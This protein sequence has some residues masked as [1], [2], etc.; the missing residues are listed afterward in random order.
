L[1]NNMLCRQK[2]REFN[3]RQ[4]EPFVTHIL[5]TAYCALLFCAFATL[6]SGAKTAHAAGKPSPIII[7][8]YGSMSG[9]QST[10]GWSTDAGVQLAVEQINAAGGI[11]G[12]P[13]K[14]ILVDDEGTPEGSLNAVEQIIAK[15]KPTAIIGEVASKLSISAAPA[16]QDAQVPM[17]SP[18]S[19]NPRVTAMGSYIFRVCFIDPF[20]GV[21]A[22]KFA[23]QNLKAKKAAIITNAAQD[24]S[25]G[26]SEFFTTN[27]TNLGGIVVARQ[28]YSDGDVDFHAQLERIKA[29]K[30]DVIY[31]PGYY[32]QVG[33]IAREA[34]KIG[35]NVPLIG[36]DGWDSPMLV[37]GAGGPGKALEGC[38]FTD[39]YSRSDPNL[40]NIK[41]VRDHKKAMNGAVPDALAAMGYDSVGLL[42]DALVHMAKPTDGN[43]ASPAYRAKLRD[44]IANVK[45]YPGLTGD[46][47]MG[48]DRN[49]IKPAVVLEIKRTRFQ[50]LTTI[51]P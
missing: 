41:F 10:F 42:A 43:Y 8:E 26:L 23:A 49:P 13:L 5:R 11:N 33:P 19:T 50:Y 17:I 2:T 46:I 37:E 29:A 45:D 16:C 15:D 18:S 27:F 32:P 51:Q 35:L 3:Y 28:N 39:H 25:T 7:G 4:K 1:Q 14:V 21:A 44:S 38:Y 34:R 31:I 36:G 40:K 12:H 48:P 24:Y 20:Q 6:I 47:T 30:P 9:D 22:A